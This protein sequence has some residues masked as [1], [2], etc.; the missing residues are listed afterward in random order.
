MQFYD[1][2][3]HDEQAFLS[4]AFSFDPEASAEADEPEVEGFGARL[5]GGTTPMPETLASFSLQYLQLQDQMQ[6]ENRV[7]TTVLNI[8]RTKHGA[9]ADTISNIH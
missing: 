3:S 7:Y 9:V 4:W 2:C 1:A 6:N 8:T 5:V